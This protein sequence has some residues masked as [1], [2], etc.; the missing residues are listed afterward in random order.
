[1]L[2]HTP[3]GQMVLLGV[4]LCVVGIVIC[5]KAGMMKEKN[6]PQTNK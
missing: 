6:Y 3:W 5:G 1:M 4:L 2:L